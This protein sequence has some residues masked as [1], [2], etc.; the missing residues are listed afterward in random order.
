[1]EDSMKN[2]LLLGMLILAIL[3]PPGMAGNGSANTNPGCN[4]ILIFQVNEY[5][6]KL[7]DA[8]DYFFK[9]LLKPQDQLS[10]VT[11]VRA[12]NFTSQTRLSYTIDQLIAQTKKVLKR[13]TAVGSANYHQILEAMQ[14][15]VR[16]ISTGISMAYARGGRRSAADMKVHLVQYRQ[17]QENMR[18]VRKLNETLLLK[19]TEFFKAQTGENVLYIFYQRELR[20][21]PSRR[22]MENLRQDS[23]LKDEAAE[24]FEQ[25]SSEEFID[26]EK[27]SR[28]LKNASITLNCLYIK[29]QARRKQYMQFKEFSGDVYN[30]LS[31]LAKTTGGFIEA[32]SKPAAALKKTASK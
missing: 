14:G 24:L 10:I 2:A 21:I 5:N 23:Q 9:K 6:S 1:M 18:T 31:K 3:T 19:L 32:T 4:Y 13:D 30:V 29:K 12:Y 11:P 17:L 15:V 8:V 20:I 7:G 25:E 26:V 22:A 28:A 27:V 16:E